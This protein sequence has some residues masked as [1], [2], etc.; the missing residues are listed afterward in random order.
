MKRKLDADDRPVPSSNGSGS[1][2]D[3]NF[4]SF[5]LDARL[6]QALVKQGFSA[7]T[8]VQAKVIPLA[9]GGKDILGMHHLGRMKMLFS[10]MLYSAIKDG[11]RK[12]RRLPTTHPSVHLEKKIREDLACPS[13]ILFVSNLGHRHQ[14]GRLRHQL[15]Y[16]CPSGSWLSRCSRMSHL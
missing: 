12:D 9:L 4:A 13:Y 3:V 8:A 16:L 7:P 2:S 15:S 11:I 5:G 6:L 1:K 10:N 14:M